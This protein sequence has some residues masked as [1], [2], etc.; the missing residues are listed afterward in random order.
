MTTTSKSSAKRGL[1]KTTKSATKS[2]AHVAEPVTEI[3]TST[4][5]AGITA[6]PSVVETLSPV[7]V[8]NELGKKELFEL[9][10]ARSGMKK[11]DVKPVVEA[12]LAVLGDAFAEQREMNLQPLGKMKVQ[13]G[14]E[15]PDGRALVLKLRQKSARLNAAPNV[16][17]AAE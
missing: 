5:P 3:D 6:E 16:P 1:P 15:L 9:V 14:K 10:V 13:R 8:S 11:K 7:V 4:T 2:T 12:M 17:T